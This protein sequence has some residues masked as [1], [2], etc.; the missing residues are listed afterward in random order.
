MASIYWLMLANQVLTRVL[1]LANGVRTRG[2]I[3]RAPR[4]PHFFGLCVGSKVYGSLRGSTPEPPQ[5]LTISHDCLA[6]GPRVLLVI[7]THLHIFKLVLSFSRRGVGPGLSPDPRFYAVDMT[8][9][10]TL[11]R[12]VPNIY[13][14]VFKLCAGCQI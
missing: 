7:C 10:V 12:G 9:N 11:K 2:P 6:I 4:V 8:A 13:N 5:H 3:W 1:Y 14:R